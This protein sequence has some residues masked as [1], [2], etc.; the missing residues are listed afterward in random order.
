MIRLRIYTLDYEVY[1]FTEGQA[2][3]QFKNET[4]LPCYDSEDVLH[5]IPVHQIRKIRVSE[6]KSAE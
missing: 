5:F 1:T 2:G 4:M 3:T 6:V